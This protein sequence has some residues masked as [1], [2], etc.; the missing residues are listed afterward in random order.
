MD[1]PMIQYLDKDQAAFIISFFASFTIYL[2][3]T[4]VRTYVRWLRTGRQ[5]MLNCFLHSRFC[6]KI[7]ILREI[8]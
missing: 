5:V 3:G 8:S 7:K 4:Y 2:I 1:Y 6:R